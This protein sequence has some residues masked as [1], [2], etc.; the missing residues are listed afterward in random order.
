MRECIEIELME[1]TNSNQVKKY[2]ESFK[3]I[4]CTV[5]SEQKIKVVYDPKTFIAKRILKLVQR[6]GNTGK[7]EKNIVSIKGI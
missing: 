6:A 1:K 7:R 5:I 3:S 4:C 2:L